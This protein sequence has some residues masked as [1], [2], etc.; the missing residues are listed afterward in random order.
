MNNV[1]DLDNDDNDNDDICIIS[2]KP[3]NNQFKPTTTT[4][5]S[6]TTTTTSLTLNNNNNNKKRNSLPTSLNNNLNNNN[7]LFKKK[8]KIANDLTT[9][10][11]TTTT[12]I[13]NNKKKD[14]II[15]EDN[16]L[17]QDDNNDEYEIYSLGKTLSL[18]KNSVESRLSKA[19]HAKLQESTT[20]VVYDINNLNETQRFVLD[21]I[22]IRKKNVFFTG[23]GGSGKS[24]LL[25]ILVEE[26]S[27]RG[28]CTFLTATTGI[29]ALNVGGSTIHSFAGIRLGSEP[30]HM[31][32]NS[33]YSKKKN[34]KSVQVLIVDEVSMLDGQLFDNLERIA[35]KLR[36]K[37][38]KKLY[39]NYLKSDQYPDPAEVPWGGIQLVLCG[40]FYQLPP[41]PS[42]PN[43]PDTISDKDY[44]LVKTRKHCFEAERWSVS[45]DTTIEL[46]QIFRQK[47]STFSEMLNRIRV[48]DIDYKIIETLRSRQKPLKP[49]NGIQPT[50]LYTT[51][52]NVEDRNQSFL[53]EIDKEA[54]LFDS[55]DRL[56]SDETVNPTKIGQLTAIFEN[57]KKQ[58]L[59]AKSI[60]LKKGAQVML[61]R[62]LSPTL[63]NGSRGVVIG[64][65]DLNPDEQSK[66]ID[67]FNINKLDTWQQEK[68]RDILKLS[69]VYHKQQ[70]HHYLPIVKFMNGETEIIKPENFSVFFDSIER[71]YRTQIPLKLA[72]AITFHK[73]Q[74][75]SLDFTQ[76]SLSR[77]FEH[78]QTY[79]A[80]SRVRTLEGLQITGDIS[81]KCF[82][83]EKKVKDFY[84]KLNQKQQL[85]QQQ[86][87]PQQQL[88]LQVPKKLN[89]S[90]L[91]LGQHQNQ[92]IDD[93]IC[94][95]NNNNEEEDEEDDIPIYFLCPITKK[96]MEN[97]V[98]AP[99][100]FTFEKNAILEWKF[101]CSNQ[102]MEN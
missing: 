101:T 3:I 46:Q 100:G 13:L 92:I 84:K 53:K 11:T 26:L 18:L 39:P 63:V 87:P 58:C 65:V 48:G 8:S 77:V 4:T 25:H 22:L 9:K 21:E 52:A 59:A 67:Y 30:Y 17:Q 66:I 33:A 61:V 15:L 47:D 38:N 91:P 64:Y 71:I 73:I 20:N 82:I 79:V 102:R 5:S 14:E 99:D 42:L 86:Q 78:G 44:V 32:L 51:N 10:T 85:K 54:F 1:I 28:I 96:I 24:Y 6:S 12:T 89:L 97:P 68:I 36:F 29:A 70:N 34:W 56:A 57:S 19:E 40:D 55:F 41:V 81:E 95:N 75:I 7:E 2:H 94:K 37:M 62:N 16:E 35:R 23:P 27:K 83:V 76:I 72:W 80:L 60:T 88:Q 49:I 43:E 50:I 90:S 74:G 69:T 98:V 93:K 45:L 31:L